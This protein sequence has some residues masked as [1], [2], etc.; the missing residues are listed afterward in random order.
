MSNNVTAG[1]A[2]NLEVWQKCLTKL[3]STN[4]D[5]GQTPSIAE[6]L[7]KVPSKN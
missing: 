4:F 2:Q 7:Q 5:V 3:L 1:V 6:M